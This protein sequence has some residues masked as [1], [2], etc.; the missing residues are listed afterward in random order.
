MLKHEQLLIT[1]TPYQ[2]EYIKKMEA[3]GYN[4]VEIISRALSEFVAKDE[5]V[6]NINGQ[7]PDPHFQLHNNLIFVDGGSV[8]PI[9]SFSAEV[10]SF[11]IARFPVTQKEYRKVMNATPPHDFGLGANYPMYYITW[12]DAIEYSNRRSIHE[13][14]QPVYNYGKW[15]TNPDNW[16]E[17]WN[18]HAGNQDSIGFD[19]TSDGYRLPTEMEWMFAA[20]GGVKSEQYMYSGS[21][22]ADEVAWHLMNWGDRCYS[23][24]E[25]GTKKPNELG[26]YDLSGNVWEWC[27]D[28]HGVYPKG[29][30]SNPSGPAKGSSRVRRGGAWY[31]NASVCSVYSRGDSPPLGKGPCMGFRVCRSHII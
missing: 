15:G 16:P 1:L 24:H 18:K 30:F 8:H 25:V 28:R 29:K 2:M 5:K 31:Y 7:T 3:L 17:D 13:G 14:L 6:D 10:S 23:S 11:M 26:L 27:W 19:K 22:N 12:F 21:N 4:P 20:C 9:P